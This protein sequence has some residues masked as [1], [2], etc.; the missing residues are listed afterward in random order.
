MK[1]IVGISIDNQD[2]EYFFT[3]NMDVKKNITVVVK[4]DEYERLGKVVTDIHPIDETKLNYQ[5]N[6]IIRIASKKD[7]SNYIKNQ[8]KSKQALKKCKDL[9]S[10]SNLEMS[11]LDA[12][13]TLNG[14]QLVFIFYSESRVDFRELAKQL[15]N[16]YKVRIELHQIGVRD[17]SKKVGGYGLCGQKLCCSRYIK[18][19]SSV[20]ISM[21]KNQNLSLSPNKINGLCGRLLCCL[22]YEND[23]YTECRKK[24]PKDGA[25]INIDNKKGKVIEVNILKNK[26]KVEFEDKEIIEYDGKN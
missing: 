5:L 11:I 6:S 9:V 22:K 19:F 21:A 18:N 20:S 24:L 7:Y 8:T 16:I 3:N 12:F 15:A 25:I 23:T 26:Y 10:K 4:K 13:Y 17:K 14:E 2:I 1:K